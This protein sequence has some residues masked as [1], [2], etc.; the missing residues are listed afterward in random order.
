MK[1]RWHALNIAMFSFQIS[2]PMFSVVSTMTSASIWQLWILCYF[3]VPTA[4]V[5]YLLRDHIQIADDTEEIRNYL[6]YTWQQCQALCLSSSN[7]TEWVWL[8]FSYVWANATNR[9]N[10]LVNSV[11]HKTRT[12]P[13]TFM[14]GHKYCGT[15]QR[16]FSLHVVCIL[17]VFAFLLFSSTLVHFEKRFYFNFVLLFVLWDYFTLLRLDLGMQPSAH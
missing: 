9:C 17:V 11:T 4:Q 14:C 1:A 3:L 7:C 8:G 15:Q 2:V 5:P 6:G 12:I 13:D 16:L 10:G